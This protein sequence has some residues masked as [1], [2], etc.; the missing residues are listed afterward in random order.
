LN[1]L[2]SFESIPPTFQ[3][4]FKVE[5]IDPKPH[6]FGLHV[7]RKMLC[8]RR[9]DACIFP[10]KCLGAKKRCAA[11]IHIE[12]AVFPYSRGED[13]R[14]WGNR[15]DNPSLHTKKM[16]LLQNNKGKGHKGR[17]GSF[18]GEDV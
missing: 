14:G 13:W 7:G 12:F 10:I 15:R 6:R 17:K 4:E 18:E 1:E 8:L 3:D 16:P 2:S 5:H 9:K 11:S